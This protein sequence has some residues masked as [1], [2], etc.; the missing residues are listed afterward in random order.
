MDDVLDA[1]SHAVISVVERVSPSV[2]N[3]RDLEA[4][5]TCAMGIPGSRYVHVHVPCPLGWGSDPADTIKVARMAVESGLF[6]LFE[7]RHGE[8]TERY[9]LRRRVP[10]DDYLTLQKRFAHLFSP[11]KDDAT[12]AAIQ[13]T[14]DAN[15]RTFG[16][17]A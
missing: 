3:L 15:I 10:V 7:A 11:H 13:A 9:R 6:P 17:D 14:A 5:V 12:I 2:A 1:Y 16:L 4:K 8:I